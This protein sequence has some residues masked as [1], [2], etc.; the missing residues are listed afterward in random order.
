MTQNERNKV[1]LKVSAEIARIV[2]PGA[3]RDVQLAAARGSLPLAGKDLLTVLF[4]LC[5]NQDAEIKKA[6]V[7]S[8]CELPATILVPVLRD[9]SLHPQLL[10]L[11]VRARIS[12]AELMGAVIMHPATSLKTLISLAGKAPS[13]VLERLVGH[14]K[15]LSRNP[16]LVEA[17][18][19]NPSAEKAMKCKLGWSEPEPF[20][21]ADS[22]PETTDGGGEDVDLAEGRS[23]AELEFLME[24]AEQG[25]LSKY[26]IALQ[27]KVAEKIKMALT[28]DKEWRSILIKEANKLVQAAVMKNPRI[29]DGEVLLVAKNKTSSDEVIRI[30]LLNKDWL[31]NYEIRKAL[32]T[33]PK[34]PLPK[35][36]RFVGGLVMKDIKSLAR[37]RQVSNIIVTA[38]RKELEL[39][40]KK[41]GG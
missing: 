29:T 11:L 14:E 21:L 1:R 38:A 13:D 9:E 28:G 37:S 19:A 34:T 31:K 32:V 15:L 26:Q 8:L 5:S 36:L 20:D 12:D 18:I 40:I 10:E 22:L 27:L 2:K 16:A 41:T 7:A 35:A 6:A 17:I 25:H 3:P 4:F 39:R 23:Q 33:H 30:I 24:E